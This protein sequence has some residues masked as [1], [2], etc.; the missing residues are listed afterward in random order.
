[1]V[2]SKLT[3]VFIKPTERELCSVYTQLENLFP[4]FRYGELDTLRGI[5]VSRKSSSKLMKRKEL[6]ICNKL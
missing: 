2:G 6:S 1:M 5:N 4:A 3:E